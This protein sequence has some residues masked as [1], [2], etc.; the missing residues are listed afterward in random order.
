[1]PQLQLKA[2]FGIATP[3]LPEGLNFTVDESWDTAMPGF[4]T[5]KVAVWMSTKTVSKILINLVSICHEIC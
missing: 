2:T 5:S 1:M 4:D 3:E